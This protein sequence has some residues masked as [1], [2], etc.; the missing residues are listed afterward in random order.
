MFRQLGWMISVVM[1]VSTLAALS[2]I[3]MLSSQMLRRNS[4]PNPISQKLL[5]PFVRFLD[6]LDE[7]Y[8]RMLAWCITHRKA[9]ILSMGGLFILSLALFPFIKTELMPSQDVGFVQIKAELPVGT[10]VEETRELAQRIN[11][12]LHKEISAVDQVSATLGAADGSNTR[13]A[14]SDNG[15]NI[16]T[17]YIGLKPR[18]ERESQDV[19][20]DQILA[21]LGTIP[22]LKK[23]SVERGDGGGNSGGNLVK[24][25][26]FGY[27]F[28]Q[29]DSLARKI[30][31]TLEAKRQNG[32]PIVSQV[33]ISRKDFTPELNFVFDREKLAEEGLSLATASS[34]LR[35][36]IG[37]N[38][39]SYYRDNGEEYKIRVS[40][41]PEYRRS[42]EDITNIQV[43]TP[44]GKLVRLSELGHI[45]ESSTPPTIERKDRS[46]VITLNI[47]GATGVALSDVAK[48]TEEMM[49]AEH[50][51]ADI[52]YKIGGTYETQQETFGELLTLLGII[53]LLVFIVMASQ[54]ES[55]RLPFVIMFSVPFAFTGVFLGLV[56][57]QIPLG[58]MA[59]V[60][61]IM[62]VGIVVK[63]G[64]V[65]IDYTLLCRERGIGI[66]SSVVMAG[67]SRLRPVLMTTLTTVL[68]MVPMALGI[69]EGSEMWQSMGVSV[70]FGLTVSTL[71]TLVLI[72]TL[73]TAMEGRLLVRERRLLDKKLERKAAAKTN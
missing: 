58:S 41:A 68:G 21:M 63:N 25:D 71:V 4:K 1:I 35:D 18:Q 37:G 23:Y 14:L 34:F 69:G 48:A 31:R 36:A 64:I 19:V 3:P 16:V 5:A 65:L 33:I 22:E 7:Q 67:K 10:R 49:Q 27:D 28:I 55:L 29:T 60:G 45:E 72:P 56:I 52:S 13:A 11:D 20:S 73:Y 70:A 66:R 6:R 47:S 15:T 46:R 50:L 42:L 2:L 24:L 40:L 9:T 17:F 61:L 57:T 12:R 43:T 26:L 54:F 62:L 44:Q 38:V 51:P 53:V 30:Q 8:A 39:A 32:K 59:F